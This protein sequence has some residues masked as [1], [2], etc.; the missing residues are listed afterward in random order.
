MRSERGQASIAALAV[1]FGIIVLGAVML[2]VGRVYIKREHLNQA[3]RVSGAQYMLAG[4]TPVAEDRARDLA[5]A[6]GA[7]GFSVDADSSGG[8]S[9][10]VTGSTSAS[11]YLPDGY[12][13]TV[14]ASL[15]ES[16]IGAGLQIGPGGMATGG[17]YSGLLLTIDSARACPRVASDYR[18]MQSAASLSG[19][20]LS[21]VSGFRSDSEQAVLYARLGPRIAAPPGRSLHRNATELDISVGSADGAQYRWLAAHGWGFG[22]VQR[23]SWEPWHWGNV[24]GC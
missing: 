10:T 21:A 22:F 7:Q 6:N 15:P 12:D 4:R 16:L 3:A 13:L 11:R 9:V 5:R 2:E 8:G 17:G 20:R 24:R 23:Y 18:A 14:T 1:V 19:V